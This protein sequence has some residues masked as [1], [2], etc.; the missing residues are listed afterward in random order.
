M[1]YAQAPLRSD[2]PFAEPRELHACPGC[3]Q[4]VDAANIRCPRCR[5]WFVEVPRGRWRV[6]ALA[7]AA[8]L[9]VLSGLL[10]EMT[11]QFVW[12]PE[13]REGSVRRDPIA[14]TETRALREP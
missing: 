2:H 12:S 5:R 1:P 13:V 7:V 11:V 8:T 4:H 3:G 10:I 14:N 9:L 6:V